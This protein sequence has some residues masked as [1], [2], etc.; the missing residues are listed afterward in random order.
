MDIIN[1]IRVIK[2][3]VKGEWHVLGWLGCLFRRICRFG[4]L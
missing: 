4:V 1:V 2:N 3:K